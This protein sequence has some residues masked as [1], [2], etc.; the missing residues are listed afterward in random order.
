MVERMERL[1]ARDGGNEAE[2]A[3]ELG[4]R[5]VAADD[6]VGV[7]GV[8]IAFDDEGIGGSGEKLRCVTEHV[9]HRSGRSENEGVCGVR[10]GFA[11]GEGDTELRTESTR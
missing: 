2:D 9:V 10:R 1:L 3:V 7:A 8:F 4:A 11:Q 6:P 5:G